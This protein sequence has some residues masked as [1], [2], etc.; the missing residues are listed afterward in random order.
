VSSPE[1]GE[2]PCAPKLAP[3]QHGRLHDL[4]RLLTKAHSD[5]VVIIAAPTHSDQ[6]VI[7]RYVAAGMIPCR[8]MIGA[9]TQ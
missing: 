4:S 3:A 1:A 9:S 7:A 5:E 6:V 2:G 8:I